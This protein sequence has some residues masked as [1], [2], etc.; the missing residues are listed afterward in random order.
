MNER[1]LYAYR[2]F[3]LRVFPVPPEHVPDRPGWTCRACNEEWPCAPARAG[4][5]RQY[6]TDPTSIAMLMWTRLEEFAL[7][8]GPGPLDAAFNRFIAW[9]RPR[10]TT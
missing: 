3:R 7:D 6:A 4:L 1:P 8:Q 10:G 9:T 2:G 5:T